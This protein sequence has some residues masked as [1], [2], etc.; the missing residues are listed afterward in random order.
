LVILPETGQHILRTVSGVP[1]IVNGEMC[2]RSHWGSGK[3][4][5]AAGVKRVWGQSPSAL[6]DFF[7]FS[8]KFTHFYAYFRQNSYLKQ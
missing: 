3:K 5:P 4:A 1:G 7:N 6:G 2:S 8:I